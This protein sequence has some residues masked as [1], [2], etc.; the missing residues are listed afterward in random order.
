MANPEIYRT[1]NAQSKAMRIEEVRRLNHGEDPATDYAVL[2]FDS[3]GDTT[4]EAGAVWGPPILVDGFERIALH[5]RF[6]YGGSDVSAVHV[7]MQAS[8]AGGDDQWY[9]VCA[10]EAGDGV[11]VRKVFDL[12]VTSD[13]QVAWTDQRRVSRLMRFKVWTTGTDRTGSV[14]EL[15]AV[16]VM[17][18]R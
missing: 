12:A 15:R 18:S 14:A 5:L 4:D 17:D 1:P 2:V 6:V 11:L 9:D 13:A 7:A 16:R 8:H 3:D 10:D